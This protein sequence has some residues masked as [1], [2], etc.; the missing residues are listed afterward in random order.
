[1]DEASPEATPPVRNILVLAQWD[2][3][4][5]C[6]WQ[7]QAGART[8]QRELTAAV[9]RMVHHPVTL[10]ASSRTDSG[11]HSEGMPVNFETTRA[12]PADNFI[13]GLNTFLPTDLSVVEARDL[14]FGW[15]SRE[16]A[17][18]KTYTYRVQ[19]GPRRALTDRFAWAVK[20]DRL[21]LDAMREAAI[22]LLGE[23]DFAAF[24]SAQCDAHTTRRHLHSLDVLGPDASGLIS[25]VVTGNAFLRNMVRILAG[26][27]VEVG[28]LRHPPSWVR[29]VRDG[30]DRT[31]SG[32]TAPSR[33]LT[34][35]KV[36]FE[37]YPRLGKR[38][39]APPAP[40]DGESPNEARPSS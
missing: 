37:G 20:R 22:H 12:I 10:F 31:R 3:T 25:L 5:F 9:E 6:G 11:V 24:R 7:Q 21:D 34:L 32:M 36:H 27:L 38:A 15:R 1:M 4:D 19:L 16:M 28:L 33:G 13:N 40:V 14:P 35:T 29:D 18:A 39:P 23:H 17:V 26:T 8:V 30:L 2:G